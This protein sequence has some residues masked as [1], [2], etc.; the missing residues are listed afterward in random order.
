MS[1]GQLSSVRRLWHRGNF[2]SSRKELFAGVAERGNE[3]SYVASSAHQREL[4]F[5]KLPAFALVTHH[6]WAR[7]M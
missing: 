6:A 5:A 3:V 7:D 2:G 4:I 1:H